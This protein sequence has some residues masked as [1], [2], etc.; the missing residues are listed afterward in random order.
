[1]TYNNYEKLPNNFINSEIVHKYIPSKDEVS[2][3]YAD[4]SCIYVDIKKGIS[5]RY[6]KESVLVEK[7]ELKDSDDLEFLKNAKKV[8]KDL[9]KSLGSGCSI[10]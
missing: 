8:Y 4:G 2:Y 5:Y 10:F 6:N 7:R 3:N 9:E 1:M